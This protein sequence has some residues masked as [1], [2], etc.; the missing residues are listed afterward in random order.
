[1]NAGNLQAGAGRLQETFEVLSAQWRDVREHW[2]DANALRFEEE[3][4]EPIAQALRIA[5][6]AIAQMSTTAQTMQRELSDERHRGD[7]SL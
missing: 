6:P 2:Q 3:H 5:L 1:M 7:R 4:L